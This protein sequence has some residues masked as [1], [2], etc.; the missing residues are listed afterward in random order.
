MPEIKRFNPLDWFISA[1]FTVLAGA[2]ALVIAI[3]LIQ[4]IWIWLAC[5]VG[6]S[7]AVTLIVAALLAW[8]RRQP[9]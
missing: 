3:H 6:I 7:A 2:A 8:R 4:S 1:C 5:I 9:W